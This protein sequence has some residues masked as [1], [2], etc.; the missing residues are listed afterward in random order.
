VFE[1]L[2][3]IFGVFLYFLPIYISG[4]K[5]SQV[6]IWALTIFFGWTAIGWWGALLWAIIG[7]DKPD[8]ECIPG[9]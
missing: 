4:N 5:K 2:M 7:E 9:V 3:F 8:D 6:A 1:F